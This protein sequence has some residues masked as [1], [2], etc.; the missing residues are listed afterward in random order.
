M[1]VEPHQ[2]TQ[3][4][5]DPVVVF[6]LVLSAEVTP[7]TGLVTPQQLDRKVLIGN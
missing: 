3:P 1:P 2:E 5:M 7:V 4:A 6:A